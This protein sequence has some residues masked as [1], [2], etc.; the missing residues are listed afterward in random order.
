MPIIARFYG[1]TITMYFFDH[2]PAH[3]HARYGQANALV[4][5]ASGRVIAGELPP[6]A[7]T[8]VRDWTLAQ[9]AALM[10]NWLRLGRGEAAERIVGPD[11]QE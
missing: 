4:A 5:L 3:L 9:Q 11:G 6:T 1:I 10:E 7:A 8:L 2:N